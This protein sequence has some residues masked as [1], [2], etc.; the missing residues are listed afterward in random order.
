MPGS[1]KMMVKTITKVAILIGCIGCGVDSTR[2]DAEFPSAQLTGYMNEIEYF[3][4]L[5]SARAVAKSTG[6]PLL[7]DFNGWACI[8]SRKCETN[9]MESPMVKGLIQGSFVYVRLYVDDKTELP[10]SEQFTDEFGYKIKTVGNK[11]AKLQRTK[12]SEMIQPY[13]VIL[14]DKFEQ[15]GEAAT[16]SDCVSI[17]DYEKW[18]SEGVKQYRINK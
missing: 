16:Y 17:P 5:D 11:W 1:M 14:N 12:F 4:N 8:S 15:L 9:T 2:A 3:T 6:K 10:E 13:Y 18:L 7:L